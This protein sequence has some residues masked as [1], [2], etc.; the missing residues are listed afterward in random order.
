MT[1]TAC[2]KTKIMFLKK[3]KL[4]TQSRLEAKSNSLSLSFDSLHMNAHNQVQ[5]TNYN[6]S[7][8]FDA[9]ESSV[10]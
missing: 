6:L 2:M 10:N 4:L 5:L 9:V 8:T 3:L 7:L 1:G